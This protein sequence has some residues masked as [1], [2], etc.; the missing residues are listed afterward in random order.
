MNEYNKMYQLIVLY[1]IYCGKNKATDCQTSPLK[2]PTN[3]CGD[4]ASIGHLPI[5]KH[6]K[7]IG[8]IIVLV[9]AHHG[10]SGE[11]RHGISVLPVLLI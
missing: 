11:L 8:Y 3:Y 2:W 1:T 4:V 5:D 6:S 7:R 10:I 9:L